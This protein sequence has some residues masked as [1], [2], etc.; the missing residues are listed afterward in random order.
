MNIN[1]T[2][3]GLTMIGIVFLSIST[4][5]Q[6]YNHG[7][8][9]I[10][11][12]T[13]IYL[14]TGAFT[15]AVGASTKTA[16]TG[17]NGVL[18]IGGDASTV[19][20]GSFFIDGWVNT[21][22]N[23]LFIIPIGQTVGITKYYA[24]VV[25]TPS[26]GSTGVG[27]AYFKTNPLTDFP[28]GLDGNVT[29]VR[30]SEYWKIK[31][32]NAKISLTW[33]NS[34]PVST[35]E[36][37]SM[38]IVGYNTGSSKWEVI[39]SGIDGTSV[40]GGL[41]STT[42][43]SITS[44]T[45]IAV[46]NYSAFSLGTTSL[47]CPE[48]TFSAGSAITYN[49]GFSATPT[50]SD[51][52]T[53][54]VAGQTGSFV[55]NSLALNADITLL[56]GQYIEVVNGIT[57]T[58][59]IIMA[60]TASVV[61]RSNSSDNP[62]IEL[63]KKTRALKRYD[64]VYWGSP[65][66]GNVMGQLA[67]AKAIGATLADAFEM[68]HYYQPG[69]GGGWKPLVQTEVGK[70]FIARVKSQAPLNL[71]ITTAVVYFK[72]AG[73]ANNGDITVSITNN[74][75]S[76]NGGTSHNLLANPYPSALDADKFLQSNTDIDGVIYIWHQQTPSVGS[77]TAYNQ[78]DYMAYTKAG[79]T[80]VASIPTT[81]SGKIASGQGFM[82]K[83]LG[84]D[85]TVTFTN[86]M[87]LTGNN[88]T[89]YKQVAPAAMDRYKVNMVGDNGVFSQIVVSYLPQCT[90]GYDRMYDAGRNSVSTAQLYSIMENDGRKLAI[91]ARP[92]FNPTD[93]VALGVSKTGVENQNFILSISDKE[94]VF[95]TDVTVYLHDLELNTYI[96]LT[97]SN[98]TFSSKTALA[99]NRF[100]LVYANKTLENVEFEN[101][102]AVAYIDKG[103]LAITCIS[104]IKDI[105]VYDIL[106]KQ[107]LAVNEIGAKTSSASFPFAEGI[108]IAKILLEN[109]NAVN[110]K[111]VNKK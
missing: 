16:K 67:N 3:R 106:G 47:D 34:R 57:G 28:G 43:G 30:S 63:T 11:E 102:S 14:K 72:F 32:S 85:K 38:T 75:N 24:P 68:K 103:V 88:T 29:A 104:E 110:K 10:G 40:L 100:E 22:G 91:N 64:Y 53:V 17:S 93:V 35:T 76:L 73:T 80:S 97:R 4:Q 77:G 7:S 5:A 18:S 21:L 87:R 90:L 86:C 48:L 26:V 44:S 46:E 107:V 79:F 82:V 61:Q 71:E 45:T 74:P 66:A 42:A 31:G 37:R 51:V 36:L 83:A 55:C 59:K 94:G 58:G 25:V 111:M 95:Q 56:D 20:D 60:S 39:S 62:T 92:T 78:A 54:S 15:A 9:F 6:M 23:N 41:T 50:L 27:A 1:Y 12:S 101:D 49:G 81:F 105:L 109:G 52:V 8:L 84:A 89:L 65:I 69:I 70:G 33:S 19:A 13:S 99:N 108:Y 2:L 96:D 98:Y